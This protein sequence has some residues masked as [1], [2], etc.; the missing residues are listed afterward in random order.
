[1]KGIHY[2]VIGFASVVAAKFVKNLLVGF[3]VSF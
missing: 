1:M 3:G 2:V